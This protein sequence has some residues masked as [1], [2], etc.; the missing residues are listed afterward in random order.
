MTLTMN[1]IS[2]LLLIALI[3]FLSAC[4]KEGHEPHKSTVYIPETI[5]NVSWMRE[6]LPAETYAYFRIPTLWQMFFE[7]KADTLY[8]VQKLEAHK[9]QINDFKKGILDSYMELLPADIQPSFKTLVKNMASPVEIAMIKAADGSAVPDTITATTLNNTDIPQLT[10][11][12]DTWQKQFAGQMQV[13]DPLDNEGY[14]KIVISMMPTLISFDEKTGRL[15]FYSGISANKEQVQN[16]LKRE[17]HDPELDSIF[18]Y[19]NSVDKAGK[20]LEMWVN[21]KQIYK[22]NKNLIPPHSQAQISQSGI[23]KMDYLWVGTASAEGKS[24]IA[25]RLAMPDTGVR[26]LIPR[27][28]SKMDVPTAGYPRSV[29]QIAFPSV[30]QYKQAFD[31]IMAMNGND[32]EIR[33]A[34]NDKIKQID[35]YLGISLVEIVENY[36]QKLLIVTDESGTW[37]ASKIKDMNKHEEL[38]DKLAKKFR[39]ESVTKEL[40]GVPIHQS[41]FSLDAFFNQV[42]LG[43]QTTDKLSELLNF[44]Q[45]AYYMVEG[46]YL[47]QAYTPQVLADRYNYHKKSLDDWLKNKQKNS[48]DTAILAYS[49][50]VRDAPRDIYYGYL[51]ALLYLSSYTHTELDLFAL[52]TA[53]QLQL[54]E[55]GRFG[56]TI[57]S[58]E[59]ALSLNL[60]YEYSPIESF[61]ENALVAVAGLGVVMAY[62]IPAY[63]DYTVRAKITNKMYNLIDERF[64][65][66]DS[67]F[68]NGTFPQSEMLSEKITN[69]D[70][71]VYNPK[72]GELIIYLGADMGNLA[73]KYIKITP[74]ITD[75]SDIIWVCTGNMDSKF[76]ENSCF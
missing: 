32:S 59:Q 56:F 47:I 6:K 9:K 58:S 29:W 26:Q 74:N 43:E 30:E 75:E 60:H 50:E 11:L 69:S 36:G 61:S 39:T 68:E 37:F 53:H 25:I 24:Q 66:E 52:P 70:E 15:L 42:I 2:L 21:I 10:E 16:F 14:G 5:H 73:G 18:T 41:R 3:V 31:L 65:I 62:A 67:Y 44:K 19:E 54:P 12:L 51:N 8:P 35:D 63:R 34:V 27:V 46:D 48:F 17:K 72:N 33:E 57:N 71:Y 1:K 64:M 45:Y 28:N 49:K 23:D 4:D 22:Q 55:S 7:L 40:A 76:Y 13:I 20:N 38:V